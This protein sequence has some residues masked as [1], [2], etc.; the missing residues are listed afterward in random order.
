MSA[1]FVIILLAGAASAF[2]TWATLRG[3]G[4]RWLALPAVALWTVTG[5]QTALLAAL[6]GDGRIL[7]G[8]QI[9]P[10]VKDEWGQVLA[11]GW[12]PTPEPAYCL[13]ALLAHLVAL[14]AR[15]AAASLTRPL[16]ATLLFVALFFVM[17]ER[18]GGPPT[19]YVRALGPDRMAA[20]LTLAPG[21]LI[22]SSGP[23]EAAFL[24]V[25]VVRDRDGEVP[26]PRL[27]WTKEGHGIVLTSRYRRLYAIDGEG[28]TVGEI[29]A[30]AGDWPHAN[31]DSES[32][33]VRRALTQAERAVA[34]FVKER[35]GLDVR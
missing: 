13:L 17:R 27:Q 11:S 16:A 10:L 12:L 35:G 18:V 3:G 15:P 20:F 1:D 26:E 21:K 9:N 32:T 2:G 7:P 29:P 6:S 28:R 14:L 30:R 33:T 34:E 22:L 31:P 4:F 23:E 24:D 5:I 25:R 8:F 19:S